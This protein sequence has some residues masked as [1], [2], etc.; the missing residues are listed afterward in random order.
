MTD[1]SGE[2]RL[3]LLAP[4]IYTLY[5]ETF[6]T[7]GP[8]VSIVPGTDLFGFAFTPQDPGQVTLNCPGPAGSGVPAAAPSPSEALFQPAAA[9]E[10][11]PVESIDPNEKE[12]PSEGLPVQRGQPMRYTILFENMSS[13]TSAVQS[14]E[15][16][17][18][19]D[20]H[21]D[22]L[23]VVL[24]PI[25]LGND[26]RQLVTFP[27]LETPAAI[28]R[29]Q[30]ATSQ[31]IQVSYP[32]S[33][34]TDVLVKI[35]ATTDLDARA[36]HWTILALDPNS[37]GELYEDKAG[38]LPP[39]DE[40]HRGEGHLSFTVR[41]YPDATLAE[42][43]QNQASISFDGHLPITTFPPVENRVGPAENVQFRRGDV[44]Q[45]GDVDLS[46]AIFLF[47]YLFLAGRAIRCLD[48]ADTNDDGTLA[49][50]ISD[51]IYLLD[52]LFLGGTAPRAPGPKQCGYD[53]PDLADFMECGAYD[54]C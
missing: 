53:L 37:G 54:R 30:G 1:D 44:N 42:T 5:I 14:I 36:I 3:S 20:P 41:P 2:F 17:D 27:P 9:A 35:R 6:Q 18:V 39:N 25:Q 49:P 26:F 28:Y 8:L 22:P 43:I 15:I 21:L 7:A 31:V 11:T 34:P 51:G 4:G 29:N 10:V 50:D 12:G 16:T 38:V 46:D 24:D 13:A 23:S 32:G 19:L 52:W 47:D 40:T 45:D 33:T 48:A